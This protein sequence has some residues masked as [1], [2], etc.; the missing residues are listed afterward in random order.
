MAQ[1]QRQFHS[2]RYKELA[3]SWMGETKGF[4]TDV[5]NVTPRV[6]DKDIHCCDGKYR[7]TENGHKANEPWTRLGSACMMLLTSKDTVR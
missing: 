1:R 4:E 6:M 5:N 2:L 7:L 3:L